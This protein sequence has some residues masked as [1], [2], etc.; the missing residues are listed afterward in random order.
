MKTFKRISDLID[1]MQSRIDNAIYTRAKVECDLELNISTARTF[2][3]EI[4]A[5]MLDGETIK[6]YFVGGVKPAWHI[7]SG[8]ENKYSAEMLAALNKEFGLSNQN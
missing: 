6:F 7:G 5:N 4:N 8:N 3:F 1:D 2:R